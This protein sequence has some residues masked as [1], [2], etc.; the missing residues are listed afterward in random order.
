MAGYRSQ[1]PFGHAF[2][3]WW[4]PLVGRQILEDEV[5]RKLGSGLPARLDILTFVVV[6]ETAAG[7]QYCPK[8][9]RNLR[10]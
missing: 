2:P 7:A 9:C 4:A 6:T 5:R 1:A 10:F 3:D 8:L